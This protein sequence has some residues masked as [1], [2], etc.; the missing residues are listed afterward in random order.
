MNK[1]LIALAAGVLVSTTIFAS[2]FAKNTKH[3]YIH[4]DKITIEV[5]A[6]TEEKAFAKAALFFE[7]RITG[8]FFVY[9]GKI[10]VIDGQKR[11]EYFVKSSELAPGQ[12]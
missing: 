9:N 2:T 1:I 4:E 6:F 5:N 3:Q 10:S 7:K 8:D 11:F 12:Y